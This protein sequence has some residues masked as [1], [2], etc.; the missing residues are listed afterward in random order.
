[1]AYFGTVTAGTFTANAL[2]TIATATINGSGTAVISVP[3]GRIQRTVLM[4]YNS[5]TVVGT[6]TLKAGNYPPAF[7]QIAGDLALVC[8]GGSTEYFCL[9]GSRFV[10]SDGQSVYATFQTSMAGTFGIFEEPVY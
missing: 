3:S 4:V 10:Q 2:N 1:M 5:G 7:S 9:D 8:P 6:V